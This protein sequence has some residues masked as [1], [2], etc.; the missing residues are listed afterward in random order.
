[1]SDKPI[2]FPDDATGDALRRLQADGS[3][4]TQ[5]LEIDFHIALPSREAAETFAAEAREMEFTTEVER[6]EQAQ[7]YTCY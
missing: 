2:D 1:M 5:P 6:N 7:D 4:M 3:D